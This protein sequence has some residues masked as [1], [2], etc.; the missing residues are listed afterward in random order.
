MSVPGAKVIC[1]VLAALCFFLK[2]INANKDGWNIDL[3]SL[4]WFFMVLSLLVG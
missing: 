3:F 2:G 1:Y 4:G